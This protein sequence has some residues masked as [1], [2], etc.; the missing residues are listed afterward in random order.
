MA[1]KPPINFVADPLPELTAEQIEI[2]RRLFTGK[3]DFML[4]VAALKQLPDATL[5][6][7]AFIGRSNVGKSSLINALTG[8][9]QGQ[10]ALARVSN[11]PGRTQQLNYF[12]LGDAL[13]LVD[14]PGYGYAAAPKAQVES[15]T[16]LI[17]SF[18]RGRVTLQR[19]F[20]LVDS[21]HGIKDSDREFLKLLDSVAVTTEIILTKTDLVRKAELEKTI[22]GV[23]DAI[24]KHPSAFPQIRHVSSEKN[25]G[26]A[27]LRGHIAQLTGV[28]K[29]ILKA[30]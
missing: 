8:R 17:K 12:N 1:N 10:A 15:W 5:P 2:G 11:T 30:E 19:V 14:L 27:E 24:R 29:E 23:T 20:L 6:E 16:K 22:V 9:K 18:L 25:I 7:V 4:G 28:G 21:R 13:H 26:L 3:V